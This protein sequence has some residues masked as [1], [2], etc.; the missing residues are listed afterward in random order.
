MLKKESLMQMAETRRHW[1]V[2]VYMPLTETDPKKK[3]RNFKNLMSVAEKKLRK[4][5]V[6]PVQISKTLAPIEMILENPGFWKNQTEGIAAFFTPESF[7]WHSLQY[8]FD[9][10]VVVTDRFHLKPLLRDTS[11]NGRFYIL[12]LSENRIRF[13]EA[14]ELGIT[15]LYVKGMPRNLACFF[16]AKTRGDS[17]EA[18]RERKKRMHDLFTRVDKAVNARMKNEVAPIAIAADKQMHSGYLKANTYPNIVKAGIGTAA[19]LTPKKLLQKAL[20]VVKPVF[21]QKRQKALKDF[22]AKVGEGKAS[23]NFSKVFSAAKDGRIETLFVPVGKQTWGT[24][25]KR[26]DDLKIHKR[27]KPG[28]KDLL[29]VASFKTLEEGGEVFVVLPEQMPEDSMIAAVLRD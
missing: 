13:F 25:D 10:L 26:S 17:K 8:E 19:K 18:E 24:F 21:R 29:C 16:T 2:S 6:D 9:E 11:E 1:C 7:V 22:R 12:A 4:L 20:P 15:E 3:R 28:D 14:S 23:N 27:A 5:E